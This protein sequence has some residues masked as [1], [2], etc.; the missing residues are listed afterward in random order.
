L[1]HRL[2]LQIYGAFLLLAGVC[3]LLAALAARQVFRDFHETPVPRQLAA[4]AQMYAER[5]PPEHAEE[6]LSRDEER[7]GLKFALWAADGTRLAG[8]L[9]GPLD[10]GWIHAIEGPGISVRLE[11]GRLLEVV[12]PERERTPRKRRFALA[13]VAFLGVVG[14]GCYPLAR[15]ITRRVEALQ[16]GV[17]VFGAGDLGARV[18]IPGDDE[19]SR[20]GRSFNDAAQRIERLV[21]GQRRALASAS[22]ELRT[23][24]ARIRLALDLLEAGPEPA[25]RQRLVD[26]AARDIVE[27][28]E[29]IGDLLLASRIDVT[30]KVDRAEDVDLL[31][32]AKEEGERVGATISGTGGAVRG[33]PRMLRRMLRNLGENARRHG[34]GSI[35]VEVTGTTVV[36]SD[37]GP[38]VPLE[39]RERIFEPFYRPAT[40]REGR[41]GGVGLGLSLVRQIA[42]H[43]GGDVVCEARE[44]GGSRFVVRL[45]TE[46][47]AVS[48][49]D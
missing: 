42:R 7:L 10:P 37:R 45:A 25:E 40:H 4:V 5:I 2:Y 36:V 29:L 46:Q 43:H 17:E 35:E 33:D 11:D 49:S 16:R 9:D 6:R 20:L 44:G 19:V 32:L 38:G 14:L 34:G 12:Y 1:R 26:A 27:L 22:H 30:P 24:L 39:E 21:D 47:R 48:T 41:D 8:D 15:R 28:D 18:D 13:L 31:A 23:P 3:L